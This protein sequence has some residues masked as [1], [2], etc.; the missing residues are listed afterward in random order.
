MAAFLSLR[1]ELPN[2]GRMLL[3]M[4]I[5]SAREGVCLSGRVWGL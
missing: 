5:L 4:L 3:G 1:P 2:Q